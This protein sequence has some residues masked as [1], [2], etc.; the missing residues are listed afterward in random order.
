VRH[1]VD[2]S[3]K[4]AASER[5]EDDRLSVFNIPAVAFLSRTNP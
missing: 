2:L 4:V 3:R 1:A 5:S